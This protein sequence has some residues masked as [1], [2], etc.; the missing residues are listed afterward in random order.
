MNEREK[1][2]NS[3]GDHLRYVREQSRQSLAEVSGAVEID[4]EQLERIE[5]GLERPAEDILLL[6][7]SHFGV[8]DREAVQMWE[9]AEYDSDMPHE[10]RINDAGTGGKQA[11]L[12]LAVDMRTIY[13]DELDVVVNPAGVTLNFNQTVNGTQS[14]PVARIG[15]SYQ[16]VEMVI[17][18]MQQALLHAR[19]N[20]GAKLLPPPD[21]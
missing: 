19:Y 8:K 3:L 20:G 5:V 4:Q 7:I 9:L 16:Q 11:V 12:L 18:T 6:L 1:P 2:Y 21:A 10:I 15:M 13:S 14:A 17:K